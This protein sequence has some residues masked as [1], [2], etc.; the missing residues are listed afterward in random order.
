[1]TTSLRYLLGRRLVRED[2]YPEA[3]G[4]LPPEYAKLLAK[5]VAALK[6]GANPAA[7][8][9]DRAAGWST[10]AWIARHDGMELMGTEV[11]PDGFDS[12][13]DFPNADIA[14]ARISGVAPKSDDESTSGEKLSYPA[15]RPEAERI[16][17][18]PI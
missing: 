13:G 17:K 2:R 12:S 7:S 8:K 11:S 18:D 15:A 1:P 9:S 5:Y 10:A 6:D 14:A 4:Y 3:A 16:R